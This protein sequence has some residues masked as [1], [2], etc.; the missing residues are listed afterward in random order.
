MIFQAL[1]LARSHLGS[2]LKMRLPGQVY[3]DLPRHPA[4]VNAMKQNICDH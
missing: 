4:H 2:C 3:K 1:T